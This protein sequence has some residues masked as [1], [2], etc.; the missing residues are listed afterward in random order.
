MIWRLLVVCVYSD[1]FIVGVVSCCCLFLFLFGL[2]VFLVW[3]SVGG[4]CLLETV[5]F[6]FSGGFTVVLLTCYCWFSVLRVDLFVCFECWFVRWVYCVV[7]LFI[8]LRALFCV[9][10]VYEFSFCCAVLVVGCLIVDLLLALCN[11]F[12]VS[13]LLFWLVEVCLLY[14]VWMLFFVGYWYLLFCVD[15]ACV[16][17]CVA[18]F[19]LFGGV[20][21][22]FVTLVVFVL[23][24][25]TIYFYMVVVFGIL[26]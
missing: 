24:G 5:R 4:V 6:G 18:L 2:F 11:L 23:Y 20:F 15:V 1:T 10:L 26:V 21:L 22:V 19:L 17:Y 13:C 14:L 9:C 12:P 3:F 16:V 8:C 7:V 25:D